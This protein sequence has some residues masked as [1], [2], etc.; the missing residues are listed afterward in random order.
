MPEQIK[1][2]YRA[3]CLKGDFKGDWTKDR[4]QAARDALSHNVDGHIV[5]I[6]ERHTFLR[7]I[8]ESQSD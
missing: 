4:D 1:K 7:D 3:V 6:K 5:K 8:D 2:K